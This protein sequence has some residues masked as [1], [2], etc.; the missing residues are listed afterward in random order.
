MLWFVTV[1]V[2]TGQTFTSHRASFKLRNLAQVCRQTQ[3]AEKEAEIR[4]R[5]V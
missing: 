5:E 1:F 4:R 2:V 3:D